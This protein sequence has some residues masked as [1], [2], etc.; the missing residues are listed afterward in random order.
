MKADSLSKNILKIE[1]VP[2]EVQFLL[3][4]NPYF[5]YKISYASRSITVPLLV[6]TVVSSFFNEGPKN[7]DLSDRFVVQCSIKGTIK[8]KNC[9]ANGPPWFTALIRIWATAQHPTNQ[10]RC[11]S[12]VLI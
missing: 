7:L 8:L 10:K 4:T 5:S 11:V 9:F 12:P 2:Q 6:P 3:S 1:K